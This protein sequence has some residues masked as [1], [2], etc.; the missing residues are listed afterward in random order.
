MK[1]T[2]L[3]LALSVLSFSTFSEISRPPI[4]ILSIDGGGVR[5]VGSVTL[6]EEIMEEAD[7]HFDDAFDM[8]GGV[9]AGGIISLMLTMPKK[10]EWK[11]KSPKEQMQMINDKFTKASV[12]LMS[13]D[14][15]GGVLNKLRLVYYGYRFSEKNR[16]EVAD[17]IFGD[18]SLKD[19]SKPVVL[20]SVLNTPGHYAPFTFK[21]FP[22]ESEKFENFY[23]KDVA[24]ATS[25]APTYFSLAF[26]KSMGMQEA[27]PYPLIDGT[28][29]S[30]SA[31]LLLYL[32]ASELFPGHKINII[33][34]GTGS[35]V[36]QKSM[37][38]NIP[39]NK[40]IS[41]VLQ[42]VTLS[43]IPR[44]HETL[45]HIDSLVHNFSYYRINFKVH[46]H[47]ILHEIFNVDNIE[48]LKKEARAYAHTPEGRAKIKE[49][50]QLLRS[51]RG[52]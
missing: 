14:F 38:K 20:L 35:A 4:N 3:F 27:Q 7:I 11:K 29:S 40:I 51:S 22:T 49:I 50:A 36:A 21:S 42:M 52:L 37:K 44:I 2:L 23:M 12:D 30:S 19:A 26:I 33:S 1:K 16:I 39:L 41:E 13:S 15:W 45:L 6:L 31:S 32:Y 46:E 18:A 28:L 5:G 47:K 43:S 24:R 25:A 10:E 48:A 8:V 17:K 9:S 34:L